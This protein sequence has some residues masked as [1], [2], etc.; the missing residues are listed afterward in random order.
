[1][2][3]MIPEK[4]GLINKELRVLML[5]DSEE[6]AELIRYA[7]QA[8]IPRLEFKRVD[9]RD[10]FERELRDFSPEVILSD[11]LVPGFGGRSALEIVRV[12]NPD[13]PFIFISGAL[14]EELAVELLR[15]GATDYI[16]KDR[17]SRLPAAISRSLEEVREK[18]LLA[19]RT[20]ELEERTRELAWEVE[21]RR[22]TEKDLLDSQKELRRLAL[23]L[24]MSEDSSMRRVAQEIH[25]RIGQ[26]LVAALMN[27]ENIGDGDR[28][29]EELE[30]AIRLLESTI[31]E[32]RSLALD[33][34]PPVLYEF[35]VFAALEWM[36][37]KLQSAEGIAITLEIGRREPL[38]PQDLQVF[39]YK[40]VLE[41]VRNSIRHAAPQTIRILSGISPEGIYAEVLDDGP[42]MDPDVI[43]KRGNGFGLYSIRERLTHLGGRLSIK[44]PAPC[45]ACVRID[46]PTNLPE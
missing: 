37:E 24:S 43:E 23:E 11:Y 3:E 45:G 10:E 32:A 2:A 44:S 40:S 15:I 46:L 42:G 41:M 39:I 21:V 7:L 9:S 5:E 25:E 14:G 29:P 30:T 36:A 8:A 4:N 31:R 17:M 19:A 6:D 22:R 33:L 18:R 27:L 26:N 34:S 1:M 20:A 12:S 16:L 38:P 13:L 35:G 28:R